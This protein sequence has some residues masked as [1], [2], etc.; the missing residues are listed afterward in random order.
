M[1][2]VDR[3]NSPAGLTNLTTLS[4]SRCSQVTDL[5]PLALQ[6]EQTGRR[7][8]PQ[9]RDF[10]VLAHL[11]LEE[12]LVISS[13]GAEKLTIPSNI[14]IAYYVADHSQ[15]A[16]SLDELWNQQL[17]RLRTFIEQGQEER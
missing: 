9:L 13:E 4:L 8:C 3:S 11:N 16:G 12:G 15:N 7:I 10:S 2:T 5:T 1:F 14:K 6:F 17:S